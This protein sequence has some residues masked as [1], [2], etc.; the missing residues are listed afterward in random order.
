MESA[1]VCPE[2]EREDQK[3]AGRAEDTGRPSSAEQTAERVAAQQITSPPS[4]AP[5]LKE[6]STPSVVADPDASSESESQGR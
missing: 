3:L 5:L 1:Q 2:Q 4:S 6:A